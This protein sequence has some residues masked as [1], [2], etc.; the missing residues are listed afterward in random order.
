M[1]QERDKQGPVIKNSRSSAGVLG[2]VP[3]QQTQIPHVVRH[4]IPWPR[5]SEKPMHRSEDP[6][7]HNWG[8]MQPDKDL[9]K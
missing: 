4:L 8:P 3:G 7:Y 9:D 5:N 6:A 2:S 1:G